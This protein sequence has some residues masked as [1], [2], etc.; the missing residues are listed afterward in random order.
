M[1]TQKWVASFYKMKKIHL[2]PGPSELFYSVESHLKNAL[3]EQVASISHRSAEFKSIYKETES[4]L[5][6]LLEIPDGYQIL[7]LSSANEIWERIAQNL[8][9]ES[10]LHLVNGA[11]SEKFYNTVQ[12]FGINAQQIVV[13]HG[14]SKNA[15]N[16]QLASSPEFMAFTLNET[17]TGV[18]HDL[19]DIY[20]FRT[21]HPNSLIAVD[22]VSAVPSMALDLNLIDTAYFSVQKC[23]GLP[24]GLGVW[25]VND[26]CVEAYNKVKASGKNTGY[27][28]DMAGLIKKGKQF[29]NPETPNVLGIYL[30]GKVANDM[31]TLGVDRIRRDAKYKAAV[32]YQAL[33]KSQTMHA[34]VQEVKNRST[35]TIVANT[36]QPDVFKTACASKGL[37]VGGGYGKSKD[38]QVRIANFPTHSNETLEQV[39]DIIEKL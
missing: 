32:L 36:D 10:S 31:L 20:T 18:M 1:A 26:R 19:E 5:K 28:H 33:E 27:Y 8:I 38:S 9:T 13:P 39:A 23:F 14:Q 34:A 30:L 2:T 6:T 12:A 21:K 7:F 35:T 29:Q 11:F 37:V 16:L 15:S 3:K 17:S 24:A 22:V 25:I 4:A